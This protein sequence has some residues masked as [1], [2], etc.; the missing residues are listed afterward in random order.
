VD[1]AVRV[2]HSAR[3]VARRLRRSPATSPDHAA[4]LPDLDAP[5]ASTRGRW[6]PLGGGTRA[7]AQAAPASGHGRS[8]GGPRAAPSPAA[9]RL[10]AGIIR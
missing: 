9:R 2:A 10:C 5:R 4:P 7:G 8:A 3:F 1:M 6:R